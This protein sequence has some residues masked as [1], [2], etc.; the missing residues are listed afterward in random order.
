[1]NL[2]VFFHDFS[3]CENLGFNEKKYYERAMERYASPFVAHDLVL[4]YVKTLE[5]GNN[6]AIPS[7]LHIIKHNTLINFV[8]PPTKLKTIMIAEI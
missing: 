1:M 3:P 8:S 2:A 5:E 4:H 7:N 6:W